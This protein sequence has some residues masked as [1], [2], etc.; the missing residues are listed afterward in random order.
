MSAMPPGRRLNANL[1]PV[2][3][4][5]VV[6][7][8]RPMNRCDVVSDAVS[9]REPLPWT[10]CTDA[11]PASA[12]PLQPA[13]FLMDEPVATALTTLIQVTSC[14]ARTLVTVTGMPAE[15]VALPVALRATAVRVWA[16]LDVP[17]VLQIVEKGGAVI[18]G[19]RLVPSTLN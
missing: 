16:P 8:P 9:S 1:M 6:P 15:V 3:C 10:V 7:V 17:A 14:L 4:W 11:P 19:P 18:S 13:V 2:A 12:Q 5:P